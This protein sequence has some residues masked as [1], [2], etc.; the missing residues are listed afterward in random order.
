MNP[1]T[2]RMPK[3]VPILCRIYFNVF[4]IIVCALSMNP[5][6]GS[7][8][9]I[10]SVYTVI[11]QCETDTAKAHHFFQLGLELKSTEP[12]TAVYFFNQCV[13]C[14]KESH[15]TY[16]Y[17]QTARAYLEIASILQYQGNWQAALNENRCAEKLITK[18]HLKHLQARAENVKGLVYFNTGRYDSAMMYYQQALLL[19]HERGDQVFEAK[20]YSNMAIIKFYQGDY[21]DATDLFKRPVE[22]GKKLKDDDLLAGS[23]INVGLIYFHTGQLD[24]A[25]SYYGLATEM[26]TKM[27]ADDGLMLCY[28]NLANIYFSQAKYNKALETYAKSKALA[29]KLGDQINLSRD[30]QNIG[31]IYTAIGDYEQAL[32]NYLKSIELKDYI[33]DKQAVATTYK[34]IGNLLLLQG[35]SHRAM[36]YFQEALQLFEELNYQSGVAGIYGEIADLK[37]LEDSLKVG[38]K[39]SLKALNKFK[40]LQDKAGASGEYIRL[41]N[42]YAAWENYKLALTYLD[43]AQVLKTELGDIEGDALIGY[44]KAS[45][46]L[47]QNR[48]T[49]AL[50]PAQNAYQNANNIHNPELTK[51]LSL[52]LQKIYKQSSNY[53]MALKYA[54]VYQ[55]L[56]DSLSQ[57]QQAEALANAEMRWQSERSK[58]EIE[59]LLQQ[60]E[61]DKEVIEREN[62]EQKRVYIV[63]IAV[64]VVLV[65]SLAS[66]FLLLETHKRKRDLIYERHMAS[67]ANL[68]MQNIQKRLSPHFFFNALTTATLPLKNFPK[69]QE[70]LDSLVFLLKKSLQNTEQ[71]IVPLSTEI[72]M[73][74]AFVKLQSER[75]NDDFTFKNKLDLDR[76]SNIMVP[77]MILQIPVENAIKHGLT[78]RN[79][80]KVL[81]IQSEFQDDTIQIKIIDNGVGIHNARVSTAGAGVGTKTIL[82]VIHYLNK[83]NKEPIT[84][85]LEEAF[86]RDPNFRGTVV[87]ITI[88][89]H[90]NY[91]LN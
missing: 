72:E 78:Q 12:D 54:E 85:K 52:L 90:Y 87:H 39:Y 91:S 28:R 68:K 64:I 16:S 4:W 26:Y 29:I 22:I 69:H 81:E 79:G 55:Q 2:E 25:A 36:Q 19:A 83:Q 31:E 20:V 10:D 17:S 9:S 14:R 53:K 8:V 27:Q 50:T 46:Y 48:I 43:S 75:L 86:P 11:Q 49:K 80:G 61:L 33:S 66:I 57:L 30:Y 89:L 40:K 56:D 60:K 73:V 70:A 71:I 88:P 44:S 24:S 23:L 18:Y 15:S 74:N 84:F 5:L 6:M 42:I 47:K 21:N 51:D 37:V 32:D 65:L 77:A 76:L 45:I 7:A 35:N 63:L 41:S 67:L 13:A 38:E 3:G 58:L 62:A 34:S 82:Q 59:K 1:I